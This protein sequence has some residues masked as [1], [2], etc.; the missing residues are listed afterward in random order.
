MSALL[1][2]LPAWAQELI[3]WLS[4]G[5]NLASLIGVFATLIKLAANSKESKS[6]T[7]IQID[8]L[9][10][11]ITK[12]SDT[13]D[14]ASNVQAVS[15]QVS[16]SLTY[17]EQAMTAQKQSN[18]NLA[19]FVMECFNKSNLS[20]ETKNELKLIA[21]KIFYDDNTAVINALKQAKAEADAAVMD[22]T[23]K[24]AQLQNE[25]DAEKA[26]LIE[27]QENTKSSRRV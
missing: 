12:L 21:D 2:E 4:T 24:I 1:S 23:I 3:A 14:L 22:M 6:V 26:K 20:D 5:T 17:F 25:L 27:A 15:N 16:E 13:K 11:M 7:G 18:A 8:L 19:T 9:Q 10:T